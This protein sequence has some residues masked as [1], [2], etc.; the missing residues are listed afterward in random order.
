MPIETLERDANRKS[1]GAS[2]ADL[3]TRSRV[4]RCAC[5]DLVV[6]RTFLED[7]HNRQETDHKQTIVAQQVSKKHP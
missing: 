4:E 7:K 2:E 1:L 5:K 6:K 3:P